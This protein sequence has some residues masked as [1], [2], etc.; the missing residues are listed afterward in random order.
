[1]TTTTPVLPDVRVPTEE[2]IAAR[3]AELEAKDRAQE[4]EVYRARAT[5]ALLEELNPGR[6]LA[7]AQA[8]AVADGWQVP[9]VVWP[10]CPTPPLNHRGHPLAFSP[11]GFWRLDEAGVSVKAADGL[12]WLCSPVFPVRVLNLGRR[13]TPA[14]FP[15]GTFDESI[16]CRYVVGVRR[17]G[18]WIEVEVPVGIDG[19]KAFGRN[20]LKLL[21]D[22]GLTVN[23]EAPVLAATVAVMGERPAT[24]CWELVS[25]FLARA[26]DQ[27]QF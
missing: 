1:M 11:G 18:R 8:V 14:D 17:K 25:Q 13:L 4:A 3:A 26:A 19:T 20:A 24:S 22:Q 15:P 27:I 12:H 23:K 6:W 16:D 7:Q 21:A 5:A 10:D 9:A 2:E